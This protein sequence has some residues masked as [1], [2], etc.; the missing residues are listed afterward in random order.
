MVAGPAL[1]GPAVVFLL[2]P[3]TIYAT[4][5]GE[6]AVGF[7]ELL[8]PWLLAEAGA[9]FLVLLGVGCL[10]A[11]RSERLTSI[12][13][14]LLLALGLL[15][16]GQAHLW[17]ADYGILAGEDIDLA[18]HAWRSPY[19]LAGWT[20]ALALAV[21]Y[22][23]AV[24]RIATFASLAFIGAQLLGAAVTG[25]RTLE[26]WQSR[27]WTDPPR[28]IYRFSPTQNIVHI[29]LDAFQ[30]DVF[31]DI[32]QQDRA[33]LERQLSGFEYF[34]EHMSSFP[35]TAFAMTAMLT[36][37]EYRNQQPVPEFVREAFKKSSI[38]E[39]VSRM[40]YT[41]DVMSIVP[42]LEQWVGPAA[43]PNWK[44]DRF[45]I[46]RPFVSHGEYREF[47]ARQLLVL[48]LFRHAPHRA[49]AAVIQR[50]DLSDGGV[51]GD[52]QDSAGQA[53]RYQA[54]TSAAFFE[55]FTRSAFVEE[56][57]PVYKLLHVG[58]P[59]RPIVLD[60]D[61]RFIGVARGSR[62]AFTGQARCALN[63]VTALLDR[64]RDLGIY[65][66]SLIII[67]SDH[68]TGLRPSGFHG[69]SDS[70]PNTQGAATSRLVLIAGTAKA[71]ML[72]KRPHRS[73]PLT[74]SEAPT[75]H[76][77]L[78]ATI[79]D[80]LGVKGGA[81]E[82]SM[83]RRDAR[84]AR[85]REFG[86]YDLRERFPNGYLTR[87]DTLMVGGPVS[88]ARSWRLH[89]SI[90][91]PDIRLDGGDV[92][93]GSPSANV[94]IGP[95]W[96]A[97]QR[98]PAEAGSVTYVRAATKRAVLFASLPSAACDLILR[99]ASERGRAPRAVN[100]IVDDGSPQRVIVPQA[101]G[102]RDVSFRIPADPR[103]PAVSELTLEFDADDRF[104]FKL[105]RLRFR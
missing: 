49:K 77:D 100:L 65:D 99:T 76:I 10:I 52:K 33:A 8:A 97:A 42:Y 105:D 73:G 40:G 46:R 15:L 38:L 45:H 19:E 32:L 62:E 27:Q 11:I 20:A 48:S 83:F 75:S 85:S 17:V 88:D 66:T 63:L 16:W 3:F 30:A 35:T 80:A 53:R 98:E 59:H 101:D 94:H 102:Y 13:A 79:L 37:E 26:A 2:G 34:A 70:L 36:G 89:H 64:L 104:V 9:A 24:S 29:V 68:G 74:I 47:A 7:R 103:R 67:S 78:P 39:H 93:A 82:M 87:L 6:F 56:G 21:F 43:S 84:A 1:L 60:R 4:N 28:G 90:W 12:Y 41:V 92:D 61:C 95:G 57:P 14:S 55:H 69:A 91:R 96:T 22:H 18:A 50:W 54:G 51:V 5:A 25:L 31:A 71:L 58:V 86:M 44:G 72:I 23:R 81:V